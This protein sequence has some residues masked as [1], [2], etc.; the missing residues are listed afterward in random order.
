[1]SRELIPF[2]IERCIHVEMHPKH[3]SWTKTKICEWFGIE[4]VIRKNVFLVEI[5]LNGDVPENI[6]L[7]SYVQLAYPYPVLRVIFIG[8]DTGHIIL[9][10][11]G[12]LIFTDREATYWQ[13]SLTE[14]KGCVLS[15]TSRLIDKLCDLV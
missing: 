5:L 14:S 4:P 13:N 6:R 8:K 15:D 9:E 12:E 11:H 7:K 2:H 10:P 3:L 1:M